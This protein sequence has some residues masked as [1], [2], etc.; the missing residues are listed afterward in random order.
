MKFLKKARLNRRDFLEPFRQRVEELQ[1]IISDA[2]SETLDIR[3]ADQEISDIVLLLLKIEESHIDE[4]WISSVIQGWVKDFRKA[5][6]LESAI[7]S[8]KAPPGLI[9]E[10]QILESRWGMFRFRIIQYLEE[11]LDLRGAIE[12]YMRAIPGHDLS[13]LWK[14]FYQDHG[15]PV[16]PWPYYGRDIK[17]APDGTH[18]MAGKGIAVLAAK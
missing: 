1:G 6:D 2:N 13:Y 12:K 8:Q 16:L 4:D 15:M 3:K 9:E 7:V 11:D 17:K 5:Y 18:R 14:R 10:Q